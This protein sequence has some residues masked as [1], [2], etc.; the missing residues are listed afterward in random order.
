MPRNASDDD[1]DK[2]K[3]KVDWSKTKP[4]QSQGNEMT[5]QSRDD[6]SRDDEFRSGPSDD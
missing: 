3:G 2:G 4:Y 1:K 6:E 5:G